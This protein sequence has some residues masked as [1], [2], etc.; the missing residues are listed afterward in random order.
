VRIQHASGGGGVLDV[1]QS[2][3]GIGWIQATNSGNLATQYSLL[4]NPNGGHVGIGTTAPTGLLSR[5]GANSSQLYE[6]TQNEAHTLAL[7]ATSDTTMTFPDN[8]AGLS[9]SFRITTEVTGCTGIDVGIAGNTARYGSFSTLTAGQTLARARVDNY[10]SAT[11]IRFTCTGGG[12][13][14]AAGAIRAVI[15]Y[16]QASAPTS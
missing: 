3:G 10:T 9:A 7:A 6:Q 16:H 12:G 1:G 2:S 14:F 4:L 8:S 5:G 13:S 11:A 15:H